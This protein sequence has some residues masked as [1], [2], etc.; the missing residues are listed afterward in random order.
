MT[1]C[2]QSARAR[3]DYSLCAKSNGVDSKNRGEAECLFGGRHT[4]QIDIPRAVLRL[5]DGCGFALH[6]VNVNNQ[7]EVRLAGPR[8]YDFRHRFAIQTLLN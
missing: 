6:V 1:C 3:L 7:T 8:V 4:C 2:R 5:S